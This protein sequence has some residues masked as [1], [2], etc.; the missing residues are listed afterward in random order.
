[1]RP[2]YEFKYQ[3]AAP[4]VEVGTNPLSKGFSIG[5]AI[6]SIEHDGIENTSIFRFLPVANEMAAEFLSRPIAILT[7]PF[8]IF[9]P[10]LISEEERRIRPRR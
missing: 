4:A 9:Q 6:V 3:A 10:R 5:V 1:M 2:L 8:V 7:F